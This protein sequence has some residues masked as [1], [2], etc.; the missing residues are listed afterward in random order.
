LEKQWGIR[1]R[2][3]PG[4]GVFEISADFAVAD[5]LEFTL[6]DATGCRLHDF[7]MEESKFTLDVTDLASGMYLLHVTDRRNVGTLKL[8]SI[9]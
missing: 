4:A 1:V 8:V 7:K 3:N 2:P 9:R 6:F 5:N